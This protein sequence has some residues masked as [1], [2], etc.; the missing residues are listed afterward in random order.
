MVDAFCRAIGPFA[1]MVLSFVFPCPTSADPV[2]GRQ[3][4]TVKETFRPEVTGYKI[5]VWTRR[6]DV[7]WSL[8][9]LP[10]GQ[11]LVSERPGRIRLIARTA[12]SP[13]R[14]TRPSRSMRAARPG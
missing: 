6:L 1:L 9:F 12:R 4:Q 5:D 7:P 11:A 2:I 8:V 10:D 3:P 13:R 14:P